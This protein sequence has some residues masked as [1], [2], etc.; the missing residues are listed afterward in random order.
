MLIFVDINFLGLTKLF[1]I[2]FCK[3]PYIHVGRHFIK[4]AYFYINNQN[5]FYFYGKFYINDTLNALAINLCGKSLL[6]P[7][8][9]FKNICNF[10]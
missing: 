10:R 2:K 1:L 8:A 6:P 9:P 7:W 3:I 5:S 4:N